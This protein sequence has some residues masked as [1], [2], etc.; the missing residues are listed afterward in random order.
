MAKL[1]VLLTRHEIYAAWL[2][3]CNYTPPKGTP[4]KK[5]SQTKAAQKL[6]D[7]LSKA[8]KI[9]GVKFTR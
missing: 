9:D 1:D 5:T 7:A 3:C 6:R 8:N 2:A 4:W